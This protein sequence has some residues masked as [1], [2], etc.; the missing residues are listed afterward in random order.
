MTGS[1]LSHQVEKIEKPKISFW[2]IKHKIQDFIESVK[3]FVKNSWHFRKELSSYYPWQYDLKFLKKTIETTRDVMIK[4]GNEEPISKNKRI[5]AMNRTIYLLDRFIKEDF[6]DEAEEEL[7]LKR[8]GNY[9]FKKIEGSENYTMENDCTDEEKKIN[10]IIF[11]RSIEIEREYWDELW[12]L[13]K[14]QDRYENKFQSDQ[15]FDD[16]FD[17]SG[18]RGWW[19]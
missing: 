2:R 4:Y 10:G 18:I 13:I 3:L 12:N 15:E 17:G 5:G 8:I 16:W 7:D 9:Y 1:T 6:S 11:N 14:G 19:D